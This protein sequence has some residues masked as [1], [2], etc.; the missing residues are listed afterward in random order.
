[1]VRLN[2]KF[3]FPILL[4]ILLFLTNVLLELLEDQAP[5]PL[6]P[7]QIV[8]AAIQKKQEDMVVIS[9][10]MGVVEIE[11]SFP[12]PQARGVDVDTYISVK[13][14]KAVNQVSAQEHFSLTPGIEGR[15]LWKSN[16]MTFVPNQKLAYDQQYQ[17]VIE[18]G[19]DSLH[20]LAF[21]EQF[22]FTFT[23][24]KYQILLNVPL[25]HQQHSH[26][27]NIAAARM[28]LAFKGVQLSEA[29]ILEKLGL[30]PTTYD[31]VLGI[32]GNPNQQ[33]VGS[34]DGTPKGYGVHWG[35]IAR[36]IQQYR[37]TSIKRGW[38]LANL[39]T[40]IENGNP[41]ILW[42]Q[43]GWNNPDPI[44]WRTSD[45]ELIQGVEGMH[46]EVVI[47]FVGA[48]NN[49]EQII[50]N[51]PWRGVRHYQTARFLSLWG[52]YNNTGVVVY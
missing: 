48:K 14:E 18:S 38:E 37:E 43:N 41:V 31:P 52:F 40:E 32:W 35:P 19:I 16:V 36:V 34:I 26:T 23:T 7:T 42:W 29:Q 10:T 6:P 47:G 45:G 44:S 39:L 25:I 1:M 12:V 30:D 9:P 11:E 17:I 5:E 2:P 24:R 46:S 3:K 20:G 15:F 21:S 33:Y 22:N 49:P 50:T 13:F 27:C 28:A 51:D 8:V 4:C